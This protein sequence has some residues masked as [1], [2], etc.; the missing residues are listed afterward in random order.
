MRA[1]GGGDGDL[2]LRS[3]RVDHADEAEQHEVVLDAVRQLD[4]RHAIGAA[5]PRVETKRCGRHRARR[6]GQHAQRLAGE[7]IVASRKLGAAVLVK[8]DHLAVR[9]QVTGFRE[10]NL[11]RAL[12]E[13]AQFA[14]LLAIDGGP[15]YGACVRK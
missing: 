11:G 2:R 8:R 6:D 15:W 3:R 12:D 5:G 7:R 14:G 10:Q 9:Q 13:D 1:L 4:R